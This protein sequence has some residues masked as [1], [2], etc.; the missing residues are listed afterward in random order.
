MALEADFLS[1]CSTSVTV[2]PLSTVAF[3]GY[4]APQYSTSTTTYPAAVEYR[5]RK[6]TTRECKEVVSSATVF[7]MSSSAV[8]SEHDRVILPMTSNARLIVVDI[9]NDDEGQHHLELLVD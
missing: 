6:V 4:G 8:I 5:K 7:V 9:V 1:M 3:T 2:T